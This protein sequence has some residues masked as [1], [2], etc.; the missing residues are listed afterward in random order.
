MVVIGM[1]LLGEDEAKPCQ[2]TSG[3]EFLQLIPL[4]LSFDSGLTIP[5]ELQNN[6]LSVSAK[7]VNSGIDNSEMR[8]SS[9]DVDIR[10]PQSPAIEESVR[11]VNPQFLKFNLPLASNSFS[12]GG[13]RMLL[14]VHIPEDTMA[15]YR[16]AMMANGFVDGTPVNLEVELRF[17][18][19]LTGGGGKVTSR[20]FRA[21]V[22]L[23]LGGLRACLPTSWT[24]PGTSEGE[25]AKVYEL[26][27][28]QNCASSRPTSTNVC[29]NAQI[30]PQH[31]R[32][33]DGPKAW[34][35]IPNALE[36]CG[37]PR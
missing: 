8:L 28:S 18:F 36:I 35:E 37:V 23:S 24:A 25:S 33:C 32:C 16:D 14:T 31:P 10:A 26:C 27:T 34:A 4:D 30:L 17:H 7:S 11:A 19:D 1:P 22:R 12:G 6:L 29:G 9:V 13:S 15:K 3:A 20:S 5:V 2:V 21:P